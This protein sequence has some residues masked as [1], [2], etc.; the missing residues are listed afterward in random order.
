MN[1]SP[2]AFMPRCSGCPLSSHLE[3]DTLKYHILW[4]FRHLCFCS[5]WFCR[6]SLKTSFMTISIWCGMKRRETNVCCS[7]SMKLTLKILCNSCQKACEVNAM[8]HSPQ[9]G[10]SRL[11]EIRTLASDVL[12]FSLPTPQ[13]TH[14]FLV[15][16]CLALYQE[17]DC[18][19][20][21]QLDSHT[22]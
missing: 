22:N 9:M 5:D 8:I 19:G 4:N 1:C 20:L 14:T 6:Q 18:H 13:A 7:T 17:A 2:L 10:E 21:S 16:L 15:L 3:E 11:R 12:F